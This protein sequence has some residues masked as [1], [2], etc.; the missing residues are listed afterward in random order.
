MKDKRAI[1]SE[2]RVLWDTFRQGD[3]EAYAKIF[4]DNYYLLLNYGLKLQPSREEVKESIQ[5]LFTNLWLKRDRIGECTSIKSYL[6]ASLRRL[7]LRQ[8]KKKIFF[9][10]FE[11]DWGSVSSDNSPEAKLITDQDEKERVQRLQKAIRQLPQ[12]QKEAIYLKYF[13]DHSFSEISSVMGISSRAVYKLIYKA[14]AN[15]E[16]LLTSKHNDILSLFSLL[17]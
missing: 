15:L 10:E 2:E 13:G 14:L 7:I 11:K 1:K 8:T 4:R 12:R 6:I 5:I 9:V 17:I 16:S 3:Q